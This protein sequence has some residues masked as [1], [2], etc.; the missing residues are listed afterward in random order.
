MDDQARPTTLDAF[1]AM[2]V[3]S[4]VDVSLVSS[5]RFD[6]SVRYPKSL[7]GVASFG[8]PYWSSI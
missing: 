3:S 5:I 4:I 1:Y 7:A 6:G 2:P 8:G